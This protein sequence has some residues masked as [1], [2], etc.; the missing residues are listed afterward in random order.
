MDG[1]SKDIVK[2]EIEKLRSIFPQCVVEGKVKID[3]LLNILGE[4]DEKDYEKYEFTWKGKNECYKTAR[5]RTKATLIPCE[6]ESVNFNDTENMYIEG[7]NLEVLKILQQGYYNKVKM[8]YI[9]PPYNTGND[10]VYKDD[11][12]DSLENYKKIV[13]SIGKSNPETSG[14]FHTEWLNMMFPRLMLAHTLLKDDGVIFISIDDNEVHN[15][16]KMCDEI[17]GEENFISS[18]IW[19]RAFAPK[20]DNKHISLGHDYLLIYSKSIQNLEC[21][22]IPRDRKS[23]DR[24]SNPDNDPRGD[25]QSST[26]TVS[27]GTDKY[28]YEIETP[29]GRKVFPPNGRYWVYTVEKYNSL[30]EDNRIW[31]GKDGNGVPRIKTFLR[32]VK[33]RIN[34]LSLWKYEEVGHSQGATQELKK[35]FEGEK[36]FSY[37]KPLDLIKRCIDLYTEKDDIILDFFSGSAT[38]A[39]AV[40]QLNAE[41]G[42]K[43]K[44]IMVQLPQLCDEKTEAYKS[45]YKNI[46]EIG[47]ERIRRAGAKIKEEIENTENLD[48]GFRVFKLDKSN[49]LKWNIVLSDEIDLQQFLNNNKSIISGRREVDAM[50]EI[51][52][53]NG[54]PLTEKIY[55]LDIGGY[56]FY[57]IGE[58]CLVMVS[59]EENIPI[60]IVEQ[61]IEYAPAKMIFSRKAFKD[62]SEIVTAKHIISKEFSYAQ[63]EVEFL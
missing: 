3:Q 48:I 32:E 62:T 49:F 38:T 58:D 29:S 22:G 59:F 24:Y 19:E 61:A 40:M 20:N 57:H 27:N 46:C 18:I 13:S 55:R 8:I 52:I 50:F 4:Y 39:H 35:L 11:Y 15:L 36:I 33:Q 60:E 42:G 63:I 12:R 10:F 7:D 17:F 5:E 1:Y 47:K 28:L 26:M 56:K 37:P 9:D 6:E 41:D 53:K 44:Y 45:G 21:F 2:E 25:W 23:L 43:R 14:R 54:F 34:P 30:I 51:L 16:R 31:F